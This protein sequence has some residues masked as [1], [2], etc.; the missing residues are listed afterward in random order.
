MDDGQL[1]QKGLVTEQKKKELVKLKNIE[2]KGKV[3][4][5]SFLSC[6]DPKRWISKRWC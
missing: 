4:T 3:N 5:I 6:K 2:Q 1:F